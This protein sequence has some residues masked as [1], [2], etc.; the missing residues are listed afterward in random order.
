MS[1]RSAAALLL[2]C[3]HGGN[4]VPDPYG[5]LFAA[6]QRLLA[7]HRGW[8]PGTLALAR[9]LAAE[10]RAPVVASETTRLLVDLNRSPHNPRVFSEIT[11]PLP[12]TERLELLERHHRPHWDRV[13]ARLDSLGRGGRPVLHLGI[14]SFTPVLDGVRRRPDLAL[15]YDPRRPSER[16]LAARWVRALARVLP[17][18]VVGRNDPYRG[19]ADGLT[20]AMRKERP[21][22]RYL[23]IEVEV[24]QKHV[25]K[26]G[27]FPAWAAEALV[28]TL[29]EALRG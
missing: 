21:D 2:T 27:R 1:H 23:G 25:G 5:A 13:R 8:D 18:R 22:A 12:R 9:S 29:E 6:R 28:A 11:R 7:S 19:N 16:A 14:H 10:L 15:L 4:R 20:T 17:D 24:S 26:D 3:E